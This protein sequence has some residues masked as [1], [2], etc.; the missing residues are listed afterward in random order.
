MSF[1]TGRMASNDDAVAWLRGQS[2]PGLD[3]PLIER[4]LDIRRAAADP[5]PLFPDRDKLRRQVAA[6]QSLAMEC[7]AEEP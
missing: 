7:A 4:A 3:V 5:D 1:M 2:F 6:C